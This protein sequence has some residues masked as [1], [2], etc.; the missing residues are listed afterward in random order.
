MNNLAVV[1]PRSLPRCNFAIGLLRTAS[2]PVRGNNGGKAFRG[3]WV[4]EANEAIPHVVFA[5]SWDMS[6]TMQPTEAK[7]VNHPSQA[8]FGEAAWQI[9]YHQLHDCIRRGNKLSTCVISPDICIF[10][11]LLGSRDRRHHVGRVSIKLWLHL[12]C[13]TPAWVDFLPRHI[14][15]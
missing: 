8:I 1:G 3:A 12:V 15:G 4:E 14:G 10:M 7:L 6:A 13:R 9:A 5:S 2:E 11:L